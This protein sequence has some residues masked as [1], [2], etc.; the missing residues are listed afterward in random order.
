VEED[1]KP[2][3]TLRVT[4]ALTE[5]GV[6]GGQQ[7]FHPGH[8]IF[9]SSGCSA[10]EVIFPFGKCQKSVLAVNLEVALNVW[11]EMFPS[12]ETGKVM[13]E[14][15]EVVDPNVDDFV[16]TLEEFMASF[17]APQGQG[18]YLSPHN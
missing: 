11:F 6:G 12:A 9:A 14:T 17:S 16:P 1:C 7:A 5:L 15:M 4:V 8:G 18:E 3:S 10:N 13:S 2:A